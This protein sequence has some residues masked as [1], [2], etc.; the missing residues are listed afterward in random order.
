M[1]PK[2]PASSVGAHHSARGGIVARSVASE[3]QIRRRLRA[4]DIGAIAEQH[5]RLYRREFGLDVSFEADLAQALYAAAERGWPSG[6][7]A[8]WVVERAEMLLGSLVLTDEGGGEARLRALLLDPSLRG[9]GIGR[10]LLAELLERA[11]A[12]GYGLV[13]LLT[14]SELRAA[15]HLYIEHGFAVVAEETGPRWGL[16]R[17]TYQRYELQL[18]AQE[19][20]SRSAGSSAAPFSVNA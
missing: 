10:H 17:M 15:A 4:G 5:G 7:E 20:S 11:T 18:R 3:P 6:R 13:S 9:R 8:I 16:E 2:T 14:F 1:K 19:R 12:A